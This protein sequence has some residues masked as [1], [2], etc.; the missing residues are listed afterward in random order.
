MNDPPP[1]SGAEA[2]EHP[3]TLS[4]YAGLKA[5]LARLLNRDDLAE[6][7]PDFVALFEAEFD[8]DPRTARHRRRICR[9]QA[10]IEN[11]FESV[12]SNFLAVQSAALGPEPGRRLRFIDAESLVKMKE[13]EAAW[14]AN[15]ALASRADP[16]P[17]AWYTIVGTEM[18]FFPAPQAS[19]VCDLTVFERLAPLSG[20]AD[21]NW[22]LAY[23]PHLYLYGAAAHSAPY[24]GADERLATWQ[25]LYEAGV[26][27]LMASDPEPTSQTAL[28]GE[29][30]GILKRS[31]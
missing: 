22:L 6:A 1:F 25:G 28:R 17:P 5:A 2:A 27:A 7:I 21:A 29:L 12:P 16:A 30:S 3:M 18:R 13:D 19:Y 11:E 31:C 8:A 15:Q 24:M 20:E 4:N 26:T 14:R 10:T 9:A 23:F